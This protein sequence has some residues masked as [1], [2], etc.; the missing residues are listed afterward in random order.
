VIV[1]Q[2][3]VEV[4]QGG[5]AVPREQGHVGGPRRRRLVCKDAEGAVPADGLGQLQG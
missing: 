5:Q 4:G 2:R 3:E 1:S